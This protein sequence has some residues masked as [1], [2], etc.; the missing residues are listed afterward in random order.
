MIGESTKEKE[1]I[2]ATDSESF[3]DKTILPNTNRSEYC[4]L[5]YEAKCKL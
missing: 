1:G 5:Y 2:H 3:K 4:H